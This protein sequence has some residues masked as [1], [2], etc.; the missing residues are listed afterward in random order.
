MGDRP[1]PWEF[2]EEEEQVA[3]E[4]RALL[5]MP[6]GLT[7]I[8][9]SLNCGVTGGFGLAGTNKAHLIPTPALGWDTFHYN[10]LQQKCQPWV[11]KGGGSA[12]CATFAMF[13]TCKRLAGMVVLNIY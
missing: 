13:F 7:D 1:E 11:D 8:H 10:P 5:E 6:T 12:T 9:V 2:L 4:E 3:S